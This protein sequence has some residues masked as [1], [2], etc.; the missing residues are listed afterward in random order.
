MA[1]VAAGAA[2][3]G[4]AL[5]RLRKA[6]AWCALIPLPRRGGVPRGPALVQVLQTLPVDAQDEAPHR[7]LALGERGAGA[8]RANAAGRVL[9]LVCR[10]CKP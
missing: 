6:T 3:D 1:A 5:L 4:S 8:G 2:T 10:C 9:Q 7:L